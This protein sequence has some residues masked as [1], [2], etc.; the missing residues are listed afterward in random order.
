[1]SKCLRLAMIAGTVVMCFANAT[2]SFAQPSDRNDNSP[3][4]GWGPP[5]TRGVP[6]PLAGVGFPL[7]IIA[8]AIGAYKLIRNRQA[9][10]GRPPI[11]T[12]A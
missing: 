3:G 5:S 2:P 1:M 4:L 9:E 8:G 6:G 11:N 10:N 12:D 7:L